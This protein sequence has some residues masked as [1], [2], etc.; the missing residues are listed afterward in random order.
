[1]GGGESAPVLNAWM[2]GSENVPI[3]KEIF[4]VSFTHF[5]H[6]PSPFYHLVKFRLIIAHY[7]HFCI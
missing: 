4:N 3:M 6:N 7:H 5:I 1:M 2:C